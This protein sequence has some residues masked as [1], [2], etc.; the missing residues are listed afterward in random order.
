MQRKSFLFALALT[1][2]RVQPR[3]RS[4]AVGSLALDRDMS[5]QHQA[6]TRVLGLAAVSSGSMREGQVLFLHLPATLRAP[7]GAFF[8]PC[9]HC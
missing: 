1:V 6:Y 7:D 3:A 9:A 2:M 8:T 5:S 4:A